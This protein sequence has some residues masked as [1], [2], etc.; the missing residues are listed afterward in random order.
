MTKVK[1]NWISGATVALV[2][3]PLSAAL[4]IA[5]GC[6]PMM[7]LAT[8]IFGPGIG[9][10]VGGSNYNILG[11]AGALVNINAALVF[12][13]GPQI[14][15]AV[16]IVTGLLT[17]LVWVL[18]LERYC[19]LIPNSVLE[20]FSAGVA[21][22]IGCGQLNFALGLVP[23]KK[24]KEFYQNLAITF[25]NVGNLDPVEFTPFL[26][27]FV[28]L[29]SLLQWKPKVP[30]I[31]I[32]AIIGCLYGFLTSTFMPGLKPFLLMD[33]YPS[34]KDYSTVRVVEFDYLSAE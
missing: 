15:P 30:W 24:Y 4:A 29:M 19:C 32:V 2:S 23:K 26:I 25:A 10:L 28:A 6:T 7:G 12:D 16:A 27:F 14:I 11:P 34:M 9:G 17:L 31:I 8:A 5:S 13:N 33:K 22:T 1:E 18:K 20:G 3:V 21:T